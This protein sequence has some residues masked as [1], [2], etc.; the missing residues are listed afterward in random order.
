ME[1]SVSDFFLRGGGED[2][3]LFNGWLDGNEK[4][5]FK[6]LVFIKA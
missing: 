4:R 1:Y 3:V 6:V 5:K 2:Q